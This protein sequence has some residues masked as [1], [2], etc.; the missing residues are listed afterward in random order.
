MNALLS[1][2]WLKLRSVRSTYALVA[3]A[4]S[5]VLLAA[6][7]T[8][9]AVVAWDR[10]PPEVRARWQGIPIEQ[11]LVF[12]P[13]LCMG[14]LGVLA[15]SSEYATGLIRPT[16]VAVPGRIGVLAA[17]AAVVGAAGLVTGEAAV[18][19]TFAVSRALIGDRPFPNHTSPLP[20]ELPLLLCLGLSVAVFAVVGLA[21]GAATRSTAAGVVCVVAVLFVI[22]VIVS[23]LPGP[24]NVRVGAVMLPDLP[25]QLV[26]A[27]FDTGITTGPWARVAFLPPGWAWA[28]LAAYVVA[29]LAAAAVLLR[30]RDA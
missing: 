26:G 25:T 22:P 19:G 23:Y 3:V 10:Q 5:A 18:F 9:P 8:W 28:V 21:L 4:A 12:V 11:Y 2:E 15:V 6:L 14:V 7:L 24:W 29:P 20:E 17:K 30:R 1:A 13:Q 27:V 16:L